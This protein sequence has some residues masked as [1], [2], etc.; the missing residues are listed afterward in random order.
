MLNK[1]FWILVKKDG[2]LK[3]WTRGH[4]ASRHS[5]YVGGLE[6]IIKPAGIDDF[7]NK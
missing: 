7:G 4:M 2:F 1:K 3:T 5:H 6:E